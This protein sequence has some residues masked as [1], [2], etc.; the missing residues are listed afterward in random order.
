MGCNGVLFILLERIDEVFRKNVAKMKKEMKAGKAM[1]L[2]KSLS[3][4]FSLLTYE[5]TCL[6]S[7]E[8]KG[9]LN[10]ELWLDRENGLYLFTHIILPQPRIVVFGAG[11]DA[12]ACCKI[13]RRLWFFRYGL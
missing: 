12:I 9:G 5:W 1:I 4:D 6:K 13:S 7:E 8:I 10:C 2:T 11:I 3:Y